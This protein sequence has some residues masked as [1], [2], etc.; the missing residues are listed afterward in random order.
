MLVHRDTGRFEFLFGAEKYLH[1]FA[2]SR[3]VTGARPQEPI[4][5]PPPQHVG[6]GTV[7]IGPGGSPNGHTTNTTSSSGTQIPSTPG[8]TA[9]DHRS[10]E[11]LL[12][13]AAAAASAA[14]I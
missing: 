7:V 4:P 2:N 8:I 13:Q 3:Q 1:E 10:I 5:P 6:G 9:A 11:Q 14:L 12:E